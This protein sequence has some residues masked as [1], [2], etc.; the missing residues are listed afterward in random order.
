MAM[1]DADSLQL[2]R[3]GMNYQD[4]QHVF[5]KVESVRRPR[6]AAVLQE[7]RHQAGDVTMEERLAKMDYNCSYAGIYAALKE[8]EGL[9]LDALPK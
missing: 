9:E 1:E 5:E 6:T 7:T 3:P 4:I 8:K 2:L